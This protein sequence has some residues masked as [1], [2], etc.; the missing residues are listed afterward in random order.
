M[1]CKQL[2]QLKTLYYTTHTITKWLF[3]HPTCF[4]LKI[5]WQN[6]MASSWVVPSDIHYGFN[7]CHT[8]I[9]SQSLKLKPFKRT[10]RQNCIDWPFSLKTTENSY[11]KGKFE[12][13]FALKINPKNKESQIFR[14]LNRILHEMNN[15]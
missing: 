5:E 8:L 6:K 2:K 7:H 13:Y 11:V 1:C 4:S 14:H 10:A 9:I 12:I 15:K 3:M